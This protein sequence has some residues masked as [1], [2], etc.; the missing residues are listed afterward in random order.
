MSPNSS[1]PIKKGK[2]Q[3]SHLFGAP[4]SFRLIYASE[5][6]HHCS[7][8]NN[9]SHRREFKAEDAMDLPFG[10][11]SEMLSGMHFLINIS[12]RV[13]RNFYFSSM[14]SNQV[15]EPFFLLRDCRS[16]RESSEGH[17]PE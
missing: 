5:P 4:L 14:I 7:D 12:K 9:V 17:V 3:G 15:T 13:L 1:A 11:L 2:K 6:V 8:F 10:A 16:L